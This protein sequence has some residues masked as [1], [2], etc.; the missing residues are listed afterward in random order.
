MT[1]IHSAS[2]LIAVAN[3]N[4]VVRLEGYDILGGDSLDL[5]GFDLVDIGML[6][7]S[8]AASGQDGITVTVV[9]QQTGAFAIITLVN[10]YTDDF[11]SGVDVSTSSGL[12]TALTDGIGDGDVETNQQN[13]GVNSPASNDEV[14]LNPDDEELISAESNAPAVPATIVDGVLALPG[15]RND[16]AIREIFN[17]V[18]SGGTRSGINIMG[19]DEFNVDVVEVD[20]NGLMLDFNGNLIAFTD[21]EFDGIFASNV[22]IVG[23]RNGDD[24]FNADPE[25]GFEFAQDGF[26][27]DVFNGSETSFTDRVQF[28]QGEI[29]GYRFLRNDDGSITVEDIV[30]AGGDG[31]TNILRNVEFVQFSGSGRDIQVDSLPFEE[32][33]TPPVFVPTDGDFGDPE[34]T[35]GVSFSVAATDADENDIITYSI[36][37]A[38]AQF[39]NI[40]DDGTVTLNSLLLPNG[41]DFEAASAN[42]DDVYNFTV[43]ATDLAGATATQNVRYTV[44]NVNEGSTPIDLLGPREDYTIRLIFDNDGDD[45]SDGV[46]IV[47]PN[48]F[49][50]SFTEAEQIELILQFTDG[51]TIPGNLLTSP[52]DTTPGLIPVDGVIS[53]GLPLFQNAGDDI[54]N[55]PSGAEGDV[56]PPV[57][58][59]IGDDEF[60][61]DEFAIDTVSFFEVR[62]GLDIRRDANG[63]ITVTDL[64]PVF[65]GDDGTNVLRNVDFLNLF[66]DIISVDDIVFDEDLLNPDPDPDPDNTAPVFV[67]TDG[68][69]G[70]PENTPDVSFSVA[71][72]DANDGDIITYSIDGPDAQFFNISNT[73]TVTLNS[74]LLPNGF[75]FEAASAN[76]DDVYEFTVTATD[77]AGATATQDVRYTVSDVND[78]TDSP[79]IPIPGDRLDFVIRQV[80]EGREDR[81]RDGINIVGPEG[82]DLTIDEAGL[83]NNPVLRFTNGDFSISQLEAAPVLANDPNGFDGSIVNNANVVEGFPLVTDGD[84]IVNSSVSPFFIEGSAGADQFNLP[85]PGVSLSYENSDAA[86]D[87]NLAT[88]EGSGGFAEGDTFNF[89]DESDVLA[90]RGSGFDDRFTGSQSFSSEI[91][92]LEGDDTIVGIADSDLSDRHIPIFRGERSEYFITRLADGS[93]TVRDLTT[94][95]GETDDGT[96]TLINVR[97]VEFSGNVVITV[98]DLDFDED[99]LENTAPVFVP[100][101]GDFGDPENTPGVSFSV[102]ATDVDDGDIITYSIDG[103]DAQFFNISNEG[104]VTLNN[105][106]LPNGF[107]FEAASADGDDVYNFTVTATDLAGASATQDVR[108]TVSDVDETIDNSVIPIPGDRLDFVIRQ[109]FEGIEDRD[110]D[111]INIVGPE[112]FD[113]TIDEAGLAN[114]PVLRFTDGDFSISQLE[115]GPVRANDPNG[116]DGSIANNVFLVDGFPLVTD[117]DDIVNNTGITPS[118]IEGSAGADQFNLPT[119]STQIDYSGSDAGVNINLETGEVSGGFAEGDLFNF[120]AAG[121]VLTLTGSGFDDR[122]TASQSFSSQ[123]TGLEGDDTFVGNTDNDSINVHVPIFRGE[124]SE[125]FI[126]R[127]ADGSVTVRDLTTGPGETD[128][129]TDTLINVFQ[130]EFSGSVTINVADLDFDEDLLNPAPDNTAPVFVPTDGDF[131]D[132]ENTPG[133]SFSVAATDADDGDIITYSIDGPDAQFFNISDTGTVTLNSLLLPNGFDFEAASANGDD[134]YDFTVTATDL[135]GASTTQDVRYTVTNVNEAPD[136]RDDTLQVTAG[137]TTTIDVAELLDNDIDVDDDNS[138]VNLRVSAVSDT[139]QDIAVSLVNNNTQIQIVAPFAGTSSFT[140]TIED[141]DGLSDTATVDVTVVEPDAVNTPPVFNFPVILGFRNPENTPDVSFTVAA[142]DPGDILTYSIGGVGSQFFNIDPATGVVTLNSELLPN[143][144]DLEQ[145]IADGFTNIRSGVSNAVQLAVTVTATDTADNSAT[146]DVVYVV[147]GVNEAPDARDDAIQVTA[148]EMTVINVAELLDNDIDVDDDN[149]NVNLR[150]SAVSDTG[151]DIAVSLVNNNTQIQIVAPFAGTSSFTYTVEDQAGVIDTATVDVTVVEP[152]AENTPPVFNLPFAPNFRDPENTPDASFTVTAEDPGDILTYSIG[153]VGSQFFN[154]DPATGVV[155]LNSELLP[156]G[157]DVEQLFA[158]GFIR[159]NNSLVAFQLRVTAT[160]TAGNSATQDVIY[161]VDNANEAPVAVDDPDADGTPFEITPGESL[162]IEESTLLANDSDPDAGLFGS[163]SISEVVSNSD[164]IS[165]VFVNNQVQVTAT[166]GFTGTATLTYTIADTDGLTDTATVTITQADAV[167]PPLLAVDDNG[168]DFVDGPL[169]ENTPVTFSE[170][171]LLGNDQTGNGAEIIGTINARNGDASFNPETREITFRPDP[172]HVGPADLVYLILDQDNQRSQATITLDYS[173]TPVIPEQTGTVHDLGALLEA[174]G[175]NDLIVDLR[176]EGYDIVPG[177][178]IDFDGFQFRGIQ[179]TSEANTQGADGVVLHFFSPQNTQFV[180]LTVVDVFIEDVPAEALATNNSVI[181]S[182]VFLF[183]ADP[184]LNDL[185][186]QSAQAQAAEPLSREAE[187]EHQEASFDIRTGLEEQ[188]LDDQFNQV[189]ADDIALGF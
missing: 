131:G 8:A 107:D 85:N 63:V 177:E 102:A 136:A 92:G 143:G 101:D 123:I 153:G 147:D 89:G 10:V 17:G 37:G 104:T 159:V 96:D 161:I 3:G 187:I 46:N 169:F 140:Y 39:F 108:Y 31:G 119:A 154:I 86:V 60:N 132:P 162:F 62:A 166:P 185:G 170:A 68:D 160:D 112:G 83:A 41:F 173:A 26:G 174:S 156:N 137:E 139:G 36:D 70:D 75:D 109:V 93:V 44:S 33:N 34:N 178:R 1:T 148:G 118:F 145:L 14:S 117:G 183:G 186:P 138:N 22:S 188:Q 129:G 57:R 163:F 106:L 152:D 73:G 128:D 155:T 165:V 134:V 167:T 47:G 146:Q 100:T 172:D 114:N 13:S 32:Q 82:F 58:L 45:N 90:L 48:S 66:G 76:G 94:G 51:V 65:L 168:N 2:D 175:S 69:F 88:G 184:F 64:D 84:D 23:A 18:I 189:P 28:L 125:Y 30:P 79:I 111:G 5:S 56:N 21:L 142:E 149:S 72:T 19:P 71:A 158:D 50:E 144:F 126:T 164:D 103:P 25:T 141:Q 179:Q 7:R 99:L 80:F 124:R 12:S 95:P 40:S 55:A 81:D 91:T 24:I 116:F 15:D 97:Q 171:Q 9:D 6:P 78:S 42:G 98:D 87:I 49:D 182:N 61:G 74:L 135:A 150:V 59:G 121:G 122:F 157:F 130:V 53:N 35:P 11:P 43:T 54:Y 20:L 113:L 38:D 27:D 181:I 29:D 127:L 110:R 52:L 16:F 77:L 67:P 120:G 105:V 151:Q 180:A 4:S 133:V 115:A 176:L